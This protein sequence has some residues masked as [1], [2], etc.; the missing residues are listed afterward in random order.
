M[1]DCIGHKCA[2][3]FSFCCHTTCHAQLKNTGN[4]RPSRKLVSQL[5]GYPENSLSTILL[6]I[7]KKDGH[8]EYEKDSAWLTESGW[9]EALDKYG[10]QLGQAFDNDTVHDSLCAMHSLKGAKLKIFNLLTDGSAKSYE[11]VMKLI[12]CS[13]AKSFGTYASALNSAGLTESIVEGG[14]KKLQLVE[15][16]CFPFGRP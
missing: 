2:D 9:Q 6:N 1:F 5:S 14:V 16:N 8:V 7:K 12:G 13:N 3:L 11:E 15:S 4:E 10:D